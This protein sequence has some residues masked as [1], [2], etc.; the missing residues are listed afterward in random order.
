MQRLDEAASHAIRQAVRRFV[1]VECIGCSFAQEAVKD[2]SGVAY[3]TF[4]GEVDD[5]TGAELNTA[6]EQA[7]TDGD[8]AIMIF[9]NLCSHVAVEALL[10]SLTI[11]HRWSLQ[12]TSEHDRFGRAVRSDRLYWENASAEKVSI[13]GLAPMFS[14]PTTR[15]APYV[16]LVAWPGSRANTHKSFQSNGAIGIGD[17]PLRHKLERLDRET[18]MSMVIDTRA[19]VRELNGSRVAPETSFIFDAEVPPFTAG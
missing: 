9:P 10:T 14:M 5:S 18:Y 6:L 15:R 19:R 4:V 7:A 2:G 17:M 8:L 13:M 12:S 16:T 1:H 11:D 3:V